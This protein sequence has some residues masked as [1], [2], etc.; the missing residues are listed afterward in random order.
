MCRFA[1]GPVDGATVQKSRVD[2]ALLSAGVEL[3][4]VGK[5]DPVHGL[6]LPSVQE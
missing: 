5:K 1:D 2:A 3:A 6:L 4:V